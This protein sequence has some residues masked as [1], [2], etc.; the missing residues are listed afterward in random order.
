[1]GGRQ[2][3][4]LFAKS[5]HAKPFQDLGL[6]GCVVCHD[7][8]E[9]K[10]TDDRMLSAEGDGVCAICHSD[11]ESVPKIRGMQLSILNLRLQMDT[12]SEVLGRAE[13]LGMEVSKPKFDLVQANAE[14]VKARVAVHAFQP[15][16]L[17]EVTGPAMKLVAA[18]RTRADAAIEEAAFRRR[19]LGYALIGIAVM[20]FALFLKIRQ[21]ER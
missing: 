5:P 15:E 13:R 21:I 8:H 17:T 1:M 19:G 6:A 2:E 7:N 20:S 10:K 12:T 16:K 11:N 9:I 4:D 18:A 3:R 14:L